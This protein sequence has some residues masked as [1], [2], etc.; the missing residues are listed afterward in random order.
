LALRRH[1]RV[2][3][4]A[5]VEVMAD[6]FVHGEEPWRCVLVDRARTV[7]QVFE[8]NPQAQVLVRLQPSDDEVGALGRSEPDAVFAAEQLFG[9]PFDLPLGD[10]EAPPY[11]QRV[12]GVLEGGRIEVFGFDE[13]TVTVTDTTVLVTRDTI[14]AH[15]YFDIVLTEHRLPGPAFPGGIDVSCLTC[16]CRAMVPAKVPR[17]CPCGN[18]PP[19]HPLSYGP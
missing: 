13:W 8:R 15:A 17:R 19:D 11:L 7:A 12:H 14:D 4:T 3:A 6:L 18:P 2:T 1:R 9:V 5:E 16:H 10:V